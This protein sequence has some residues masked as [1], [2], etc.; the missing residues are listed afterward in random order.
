MNAEEA[1]HL[2]FGEGLEGLDSGDE[3]EIDEDPAF[4]LPDPSHS[5]SDEET[6]PDWDLDEARSSVASS[7]MRLYIIVNSRVANTLTCPTD[8]NTGLMETERT[9]SRKKGKGKGKWEGERER[10]RESEREGERDR[11][12]E[13]KGEREGEQE[14]QFCTQFYFLGIDRE[15]Y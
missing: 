3:S 2:V 5:S 13:G 10:E 11:E 8:E 9:G 12:G 7:G 14:S 1:L 15:F 4:P 6:D